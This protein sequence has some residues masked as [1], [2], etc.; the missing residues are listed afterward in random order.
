MISLSPPN[1]TLS[2]VPST[3]PRSAAG[4]ASVGTKAPGGTGIVATCVAPTCNI[5]VLPVQPVYSTTTPADQDYV[6]NAIVRLI[7]RPPVTS[8]NVFVTTTQSGT[9]PGCQPRLIPIPTKINTPG[10]SDTLR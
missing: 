2:P 10:S 8:K 1:T 3:P 6:G 7:T 5:R 9:I 4:T